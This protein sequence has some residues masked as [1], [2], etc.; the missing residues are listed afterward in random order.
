MASVLYFHLRPYLYRRC[1]YSVLGVLF[2][3]GIYSFLF[4]GLRLIEKTVY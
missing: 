4:Y 3:M 1:F 2:A